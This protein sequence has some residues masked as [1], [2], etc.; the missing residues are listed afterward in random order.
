MIRRNKVITMLT[1]A[2]LIS[3]LFTA[4]PQ[5]VMASDYSNCT[6]SYYSN[7]EGKCK[8]ATD[9]QGITWDY[10]VRDDGNIS[11]WGTSTPVETMTLPSELDGH[12]VVRVGKLVKEVNRFSDEY[13]A[14]IE[15]CK[16][17]KKVVVPEGVT[18]LAESALYY[19]NLNDVTLP[20]SLKSMG[21]N[22]LNSTWKNAHKASSGFVVFNGILIDGTAATGEVSIPSDIKCIADYAFYMN[23]NITKVTIP[24]GVKRI[25]ED[26]FFRCENLEKAEMNEGLEVIGREAF[27]ES[28]KLKDS[29]IPSTVKELGYKAFEPSATRVQDSGEKT[30]EGLNI[31]DGVLLSGK[32]ASGDIVIPSTVTKIADNAFYNNQNITSVKIPSS[33]KEIG[34]AAFAGTNIKEVVIP[35]SIKRIPSNAF[36][37]CKKLA[38]V[39]F[40]DGIETIG[41]CAFSGCDLTSIDLPTSITKIEAGAFR[42]CKKLK[43]VKSGSNITADETAFDGTIV[44]GNPGSNGGGNGD[45]DGTTVTSPGFISGWNKGNDGKWYYY[46]SND[47]HKCTGWK[48]DKDYNS[49]FY[50]NPD[51]SMRTGWFYDYTYGSWFYLNGNGTMKTGWLN[52]GGTWYYLNGNGTMKTGWF[53]ENDGIWYFLYGNGAMAHDVWIGNYYVNSSGAWTATR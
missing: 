33:V 6:D 12:K 40:E 34:T 21:R 41:S 43:T 19:D 30:S 42:G 51:G 23:N 32:D 49:W 18:E 22:S 52:D 3:G 46:D 16:S 14:Y 35:G 36:E 24:A 37:Q 8:S 50:L 25:G 17:I 28:Y 13:P 47:G 27:A 29:I 26:A 39:T 31:Y 10:Y 53:C 15:K 48:F 20:N 44:E 45:D 4:L 9:S 7:V 1:T 11:L 5:G 2:A 38:Y